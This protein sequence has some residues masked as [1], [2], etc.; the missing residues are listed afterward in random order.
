[1]AQISIRLEDLLLEVFDAM[2]A[3]A[4]HDRSDE[5]RTA[6]YS[7][8][9][10]NAPRGWNEHHH[11]MSSVQAA[12]E[13]ALRVLET[14]RKRWTERER[15]DRD[16]QETAQAVQNLGA[17]LVELWL[18]AREMQEDVVTYAGAGSSTQRQFDQLIATL[19]TLSR[20]LFNAARTLNL[21]GA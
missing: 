20:P 3:A 10:L 19:D 6:L 13:E 2:A 15:G 17:M 5:V 12:S 16:R 11:G 18:L 4:H 21:P 8:A 7:H 9:H 14:V 1:M